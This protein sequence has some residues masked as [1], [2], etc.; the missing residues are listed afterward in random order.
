[1]GTPPRQPSNEQLEFGVLVT[2][3]TFASVVVTSYAAFEISTHEV[4]DAP[5]GV[6][7]ALG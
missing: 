7:G 1:M 2:L 4:G 6:V 3:L 5:S